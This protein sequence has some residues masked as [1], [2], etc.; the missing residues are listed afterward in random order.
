MEEKWLED[1][2]ESI[3]SAV[4]KDFHEKYYTP[5]NMAIIVSGKIHETDC[6]TSELI[7]RRYQFT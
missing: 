3:T 4:L 2:F 5:E 1:D 7:L 6:K